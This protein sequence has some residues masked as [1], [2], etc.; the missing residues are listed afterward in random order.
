MGVQ[1]DES[2]WFALSLLIMW[3]SGVL[4]ALVCHKWQAQQCRAVLSTTNAL[5]GKC[6]ARAQ[7]VLSS[8]LAPMMGV[9]S[10]ARP[11]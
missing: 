10:M 1:G 11:A 8:V 9:F 5:F 6:S 3:S 7:S 4:A 2:F